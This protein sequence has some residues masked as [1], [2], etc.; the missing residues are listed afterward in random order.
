MRSNTITGR[1]FEYKMTK[2]M[3]KA[4]LAEPARKE[5]KGSNQE[6]LCK[7]VNEDLGIIGTCTRVLL[8]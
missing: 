5:F 7:C 3:A 8:W 1:T 6:Y 2:Q 4:L